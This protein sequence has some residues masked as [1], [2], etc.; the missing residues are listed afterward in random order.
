L[1]DVAES[2]FDNVASAAVDGVELR[3][4][5]ASGAAAF[6]VTD[7]IGRLGDDADDAAIAQVLADRA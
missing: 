3:R 2:A 4:T 5:S 7:L 6:A 1:L